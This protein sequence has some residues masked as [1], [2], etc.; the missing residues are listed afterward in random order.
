MVVLIW[1]SNERSASLTHRWFGGRASAMVCSRSSMAW[2][3]SQRTNSAWSRSVVL[4][5]SS[6]QVGAASIDA[7]SN[8][9]TK[10]TW[11]ELSHRAI[12]SH[13]PLKSNAPDAKDVAEN[14]FE[15]K[16]FKDDCEHRFLALDFRVLGS[17]DPPYAAR[18][19]ERARTRPD[20]D[21]R[22]L[23]GAP[24]YGG[25]SVACQRASR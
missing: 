20:R 7:A 12:R 14:N 17:T 4:I 21:F 3:S 2:P 19:W 25:G 22:R 18:R 10:S 13:F 1:E 23:C 11:S 15:A 16:S 5:V 24:A 8:A 9:S 6:S